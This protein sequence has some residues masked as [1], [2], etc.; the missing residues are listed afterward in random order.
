MVVLDRVFALAAAA[1]GGLC[2]SESAYIA[3]EH[4]FLAKYRHWRGRS[5]RAYAF[6]VY[7]PGDCP[8][9]ADAVLLVA[10]R[11]GAALACLDLGE[12]PEGALARLRRRFALQDVEFHIHVLAE[13][14]GDR[15]ALVE[16]LAP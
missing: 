14:A 7:A 3:H 2:E 9:Y 16:D 5:G 12:F 1:Q 6:S 11:R 8:A 10:S 15:R 13:R 4:V